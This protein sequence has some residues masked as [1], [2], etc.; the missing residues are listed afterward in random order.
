[1][2]TDI[3]KTCPIEAA[4]NAISGRWKSVILFRLLENKVIRFNELHRSIPDIT[5]RMLT[6][7]LRELEQHGVVHREVYHE[8][9]LKVEYSLTPLG[10]ELEENI[11]SLVV[12]GKKYL[13]QKS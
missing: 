11:K 8:M 5:R 10:Q 1:M 6:L 4:A 12:W 13:K 7:Q 3:T 2:K 9:P